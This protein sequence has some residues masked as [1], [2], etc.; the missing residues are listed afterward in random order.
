MS[1]KE[2]VFE[3]LIGP[4]TKRWTDRKL[5]RAFGYN[6]KTGWDL[7]DPMPAAPYTRYEFRH[8]RT[9]AVK[10]YHIRRVAP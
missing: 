5:T 7:Q 4:K 8:S 2:P 9:G 6:A 1:A 3:V 10:V